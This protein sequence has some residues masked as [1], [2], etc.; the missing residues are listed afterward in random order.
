[1][2]IRNTTV[3]IS[4]MFTKLLKASKFDV[5]G[6][7]AR[8]VTV[9][10]TCYAYLTIHIRKLCYVYVEYRFGSKGKHAVDVE[11]ACTSVT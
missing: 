4:N 9:E 1:M 2:L 10:S 8:S 11:P 6:R 5:S 3:G 7:A